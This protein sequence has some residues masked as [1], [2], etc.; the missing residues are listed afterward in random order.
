MLRR[1]PIPRTNARTHAR[2]RARTRAQTLGALL[3]ATTLLRG[4]ALKPFEGELHQLLLTV[5]ADDAPTVQ[6]L[7][8]EM[9]EATALK[10]E[11]P[12]AKGAEAEDG[13]GE[14]DVVGEQ[15]AA[16]TPAGDQGGG[17]VEG[18]AKEGL[19]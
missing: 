19:A 15:G 4:L 10:V 1:Q 6:V 2:T 12:P 16:A 3:R 17:A 11:A 7:A 13:G 14:E 8:R 9:A 5:L 18:R